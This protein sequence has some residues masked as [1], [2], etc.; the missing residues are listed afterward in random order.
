MLIEFD[1]ICRKEDI[2]YPIEGGT[3]LGAVRNN[4]FIP[5]DDDVDV[6]MTRDEYNKFFLACEKY[7]ELPPKSKRKPHINVYELNF[8]NLF[9]GGK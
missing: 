3:L 8:G 1:R 5:W 7:M 4:K 9:E 6:S 2:K